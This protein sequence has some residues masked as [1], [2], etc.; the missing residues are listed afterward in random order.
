[1]KDKDKPARKN[2]C[3]DC[4]QLTSDNMCKLGALY[5]MKRCI[6]TPD[7]IEKYLE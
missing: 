6:R 4:N 2:C 3:T 1:M 5:G 7:G